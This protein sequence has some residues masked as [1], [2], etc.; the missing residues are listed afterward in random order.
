MRNVSRRLLPV[1][2]VAAA[3]AG[4]GKERVSEE[5]PPPA[6]SFT[7]YPGARYLA[8]LT[9]MT[10]QAHKVINPNIVE[11]PPTAIY[12]T[13][14][15]LEK[16]A[17]F[18]AKSYG[19]NT[20]APDATNNLSASKPP[21]YYRS[22][23]LGTDAKSIEPLLRKMNLKTDVTKA[24]GAYRAVEIEPRPNRPRVTISRPYF[25]VLNS[26]VVD[27]TIILMTR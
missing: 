19:Y 15:P 9:E 8:Q 27:R 23:D 6:F 25:D 5:V 13:D 12:D 10:K 22:G 3:V 11:P 20:I 4:C 1:L 18:Y 24:Q 21:A 2:L 14:A 16:V 7:V 26:Q 17:E